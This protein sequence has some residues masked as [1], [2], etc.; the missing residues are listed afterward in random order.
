[1]SKTLWYKPKHKKKYLQVYV[2]ICNKSLKLLNILR[3]GIRIK[4][5]VSD[6]YLLFT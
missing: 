4:P 2:N 6:F 3:V 5:Y 1:M